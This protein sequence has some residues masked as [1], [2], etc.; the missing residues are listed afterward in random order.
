MTEAADRVWNDNPTGEQ[1]H[2]KDALGDRVDQLLG[3]EDY[4]DTGDRRRGAAGGGASR[5]PGRKPQK[6]A[7][8][9]ALITSRSIDGRNNGGRSSSLDP[10]LENVWATGSMLSIGKLEHKIK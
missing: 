1:R 3:L 2:W 9:F 5:R 6:R 10:L 8:L 7:S 4:A